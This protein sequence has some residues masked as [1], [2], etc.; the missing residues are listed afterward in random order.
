M[1]SCYIYILHLLLVLCINKYPPALSHGM[2]THGKTKKHLSQI[3]HFVASH[4][5]IHKNYGLWFAANKRNVAS[6]CGRLGLRYT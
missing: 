4:H 2:F 1:A 6:L 5:L 3:G